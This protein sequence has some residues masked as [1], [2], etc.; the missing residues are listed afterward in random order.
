MNSLLKTCDTLNMQNQCIHL[1]SEV[2]LLVKCIIFQ[3][4]LYHLATVRN[5][6]KLTTHKDKSPKINLL[7]TMI[8]NVTS[9]ANLGFFG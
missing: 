5:G 9:V 1:V 3:D 6:R 8:Q 2:H 7:S 4:P